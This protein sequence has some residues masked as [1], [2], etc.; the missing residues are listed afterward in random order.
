MANDWLSG[1]HQE[2]AGSIIVIVGL[3]CIS[4]ISL[5]YAK[6]SA[7]PRPRD[8][9]EWSFVGPSLI[10]CILNANLVNAII[11]IAAGSLM[12]VLLAAEESDDRSNLFT[13]LQIV[14]PL[15]YGTSLLFPL[16]ALALVAYM[17][18]RNRMGR[19]T[20]AFDMKGGP[21]NAR[22]FM[23]GAHTMVLAAGLGS[24][25]AISIIVEID[26]GFGIAGGACGV[27]SAQDGSSL[28]LYW[29]PVMFS[30]ILFSMTIL[31]S[32]VVYRLWHYSTS[33]TFRRETSRLV[34]FVG[35]E[36]VIL[37]AVVCAI[38]VWGS[39]GQSNSGFLTNA[40]W[41]CA[42]VLH[43]GLFLWSERKWGQLTS[44]RFVRFEKRHTDDYMAKEY[45]QKV[46]HQN[47]EKMRERAATVTPMC[48]EIV[49]H[50][51]PEANTCF[52]GRTVTKLLALEGSAYDETLAYL[53][54]FIAEQWNLHLEWTKNARRLTETG[55]GVSLREPDW[56]DDKALKLENEENIRLSDTH[57]S[58]LSITHSQEMGQTNAEG[59]ALPTMGR[60]E[61]TPR[62][63]IV[64]IVVILSLIHISEPTRPY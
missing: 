37:V 14:C 15:D 40:M 13:A 35:A 43:A 1:D 41:A 55:E 52:L 28:P 22:C 34:G 53:P 24:G 48:Q 26:T 54:E 63:S 44:V 8:P 27:R 50:S 51:F 38:L 21:S 58:S 57:D 25:L 46:R 36:F 29:M 33:V 10:L 47:L 56:E 7:S 49:E 45:E 59:T 9:H 11:E 61:S 3:Q 39:V 6:F 64:N 31:G 32:R 42:G 18:G 30:A 62:A 17:F 4:V 12:L 2:R 5:V 23:L 19:H 20:K 16:Y 60:T